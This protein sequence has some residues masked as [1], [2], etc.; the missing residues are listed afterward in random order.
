MASPEKLQDMM[1]NLEKLSGIPSV[2][3]QVN[4]LLENPDTDAQ[5]LAKIIMLDASLTAQILKICNSA[6][7]GFSRK[8]GTISE[9]VSILG[10]KTLKRVIFTIISHSALNRPVEG[11]GLEKGALWQNALTCAVYAQHI[12]ENLKFRDSEMVFVAA[13]LRDIGKIAM[14]SYLSGQAQSIEQEAFQQKCAFNEAEEHVLGLSHT[15]AGSHLATQWNLPSHLINVILYHHHP[16]KLPPNTS[17]EDQQVV[18]MVHLADCFTMMAG[19]GVGVDGLM[20]PL[21]H[22]VF[23]FLNLPPDSQQME[24]LYAD[25]LDLKGKIQAMSQAL[26]F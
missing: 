24:A 14:E 5:D 15:E 2:A 4:Q 10:Y 12:A 22:A 7:Y 11:Y 19:E 8:I 17:V 3:L 1:E 6:E 25:L 20:Y 9:A 26:S 13:L 16:S 21:D 18:A 23:Q